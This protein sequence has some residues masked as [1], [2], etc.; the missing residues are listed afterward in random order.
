MDPHQAHSAASGAK[1]RG[2][3]QAGDLLP[4]ALRSLGVPSGR[5]TRQVRAAW[6]AAC[7]DAW[8]EHTQLKRLVGGVLEIEV[9]PA[10][11]RDELTHYHRDRVL[12]V[13]RT[14]LPDVPLIGVRFVSGA[15]GQDLPDGDAR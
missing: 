14:A 6:N 3:R 2:P 15:G 10:A 7:E 1:A 13:L 8:R 4:G 5:L 11:L 9:G 12:D